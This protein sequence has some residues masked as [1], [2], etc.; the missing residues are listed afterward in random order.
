MS[1]LVC[2][3][4]SV[5][6]KYSGMK[7]H[8]LLKSAF[9]TLRPFFFLCFCSCVVPSTVSEMSACTLFTENTIENNNK[10]D[11]FFKLP[12][13]LSTSILTL[14]TSFIHGHEFISKLPA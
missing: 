10:E 8:Y 12:Y 14:L 11:E 7:V 4:L 3:I 2:Q 6:G 13:R 9:I 5:I 1:L